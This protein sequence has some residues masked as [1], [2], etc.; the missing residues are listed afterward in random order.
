ML[1]SAFTAL[2]CGGL[3]AFARVIAHRL[4]LMLA[5]GFL[6]VSPL[7]AITGGLALAHVLAAVF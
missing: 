7:I 2:P 4:A 5:V 6:A 3:A 1:R